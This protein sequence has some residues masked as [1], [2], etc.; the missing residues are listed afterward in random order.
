M[1]CSQGLILQYYVRV[2][3]IPVCGN[4]GFRTA[5]AL[6]R[7][8]VDKDGTVSFEY[9]S[10]PLLSSAQSLLRSVLLLAMFPSRPP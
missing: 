9:V 2:E 10:S 4:I 8:V 1:V 5:N 6:K 7:L 3:G